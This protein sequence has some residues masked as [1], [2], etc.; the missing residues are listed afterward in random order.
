MI[1]TD[2]EIKLERF[3]FP[4]Y[5]V[6]FEAENIDEANKMLQNYLFPKK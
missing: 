6:S 4:E 5:S 1:K 2:K 3:C